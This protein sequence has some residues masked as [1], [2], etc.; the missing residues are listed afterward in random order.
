MCLVTMFIMYKYVVVDLLAYIVLT[1]TCQS[2]VWVDSIHRTLELRGSHSNREKES[3]FLLGCS[4][5]SINPTTPSMIYDTFVFIQFNLQ[6][7]TFTFDHLIY[8][9]QI[10]HLFVI[11]CPSPSY[12][13]H[14]DPITIL[15]FMSYQMYHLSII[16]YHFII[17]FIYDFFISWNNS[18]LLSV[19]FIG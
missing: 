15:I 10:I 3:G 12:L 8:L 2:S 7:Y 5:Q 16:I 4:F 14:F 17:L 6:F 9:K 13:Y 18:C 11:K 19:E 1:N